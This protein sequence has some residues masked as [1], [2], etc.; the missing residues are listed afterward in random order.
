[1]FTRTRVRAFSRTVELKVLQPIPKM[2][3]R[4]PGLAF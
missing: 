1:M 3:E 2:C 4:R